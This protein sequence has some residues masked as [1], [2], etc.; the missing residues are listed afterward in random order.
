MQADGTPP[1]Q[2]GQG[3]VPL[4][5]YLRGRGLNPLADRLREVALRIDAAMAAVAGPDAAAA[6]GPRVLQ[7]AKELSALKRLAEADVAP[8]LQVSIGFSDADGD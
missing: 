7:A 3:A 1:V 6:D 8:A 5:T 2:P 4:E